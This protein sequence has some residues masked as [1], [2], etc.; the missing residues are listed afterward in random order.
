MRPLTKKLLRDLWQLRAQVAAIVA[1]IAAGVA[2]FHAMMGAYDSVAGARADFYARYRMPDV[3]AHVSRAPRSVAR[4]LEAIAGVAEVRPRVVVDVGAEVPGVD[5]PA[6][7]HLVSMPRAG[8]LAGVLLRRGVPPLRPDE[9]V[10]NEVFAEANHLELGAAL[11]VTLHQ[12]RRVLRVVGVGVSPEFVMQVRAGD[13]LPDNRRYGVAWMEEAALATQA[14]M[15]GA[16]ND[17]VVQL[18]PDARVAEVIS[19]M[20]ERLAAY[21][22]L[23][24]QDR[25]DGSLSDHIL[26]DKLRNLHAVARVVPGIFL[27]VA[28]F[29]LNVVLGRL[30]ATQ[31]VQIGTLKAFGMSDLRVGAHYLQLT[32]LIVGLGAIAGAALGARLGGAMTD[33]YR[34]Y[35]RF[36]DL[37]FRADPSTLIT[38]VGVAVLAGSAGALSAVRRATALPPAEAM[39]PE[40]PPA[41]RASIVDHPAARRALST[42]ARMV[43]RNLLR[44]PGRTALSIAAMALAAAIV[45]LTRGVLDTLEVLTDLQFVDS[46]RSDATVIF[47]E[48][49][50][51]SAV[52]DLAR[53]PGVLRVEPFHAVAVTLH[54]EQHRRRTA[55][56][57]LPRGGELHRLVG[58]DRRAV[59]VP[60]EGL[61]L[62]RVLAR[63]LGVVPGDRLDVELLQGDRRT[64]SAQVAAVVDDVFGVAATMD[65]EAL[66]RFVRSPPL[67]SGAEA[68]FDPAR[69]ADVLARL[70][71]AAMVASVTTH[72][73]A[74]RSF[75]EDMDQ[76]LA[77]TQRVEVSLAFVIAFA[78]VYNA[79]RTALAERSRELASMRVLGFTT[80]EVTAVLVGEISAITLAAL[81]PGFA[82]GYGLSYLVVKATSSD[83]YR[84]PFALSPASFSTA[85]LV[86]LASAL[87]SSVVVAA[88]VRKLDLVGVLKTRD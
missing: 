6:T 88:R 83:L 22:T 65:L 44:R 66:H 30:V 32:L 82:L 27:A 86:V 52:H 20:D 77:S 15:A 60:E 18:A 31:R 21:G 59:I 17:L 85:A 37:A 78:V 79:A 69:E 8:A 42:A 40:P 28:A 43:V 61:V 12:Q 25:Y 29:L 84:L 35:Y 45:V 36:P 7:L 64:R 68:T 50:P 16:F 4:E 63:D 13:L 11:G 23:G 54:H 62:S 55:L 10:V 3:F 51:P 19:R 53:I 47:A 76:T 1:V 57:G 80:A 56:T 48:S 81:P 39:R 46:L 38:A 34:T 9:V 2:V 87:F 24:A 49:R 26:G 58:E 67:A 75:H 5:E 74:L 71:G 70:R 41:F 14:D 72:R 73:D 33:L